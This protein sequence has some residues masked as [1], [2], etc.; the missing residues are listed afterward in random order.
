MVEWLSGL[1]LWIFCLCNRGTVSSNHIGVIFLISFVLALCDNWIVLT[2]FW[3][4]INII[5]DHG[6][7]TSAV[8]NILVTFHSRDCSEVLSQELWL[9]IALIICIFWLSQQ[10]KPWYSGYKILIMIWYIILCWKEIYW[11]S[12]GH[13]ANL[14]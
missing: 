5:C 3:L 7:Y 1:Q 13:S 14:G 12:R 2:G 9:K 4:E 11:F 10:W 8:A 6:V